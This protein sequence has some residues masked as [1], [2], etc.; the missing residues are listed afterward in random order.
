MLINISSG[1]GVDEVCRA[2]FHF[3]H[4][5]E[6]KY[7]FEVVKLEYAHCEDGYKSILLKSDD[8]ALLA[9]EG[10]YLWRCQSPFRPKI[11]EKTGTFLWLL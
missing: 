4:W 11:R 1:N 6:A 9:L 8:E 3:L 2:L 10:T 7:T 5:L